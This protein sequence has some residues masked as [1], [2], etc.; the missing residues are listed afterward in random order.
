MA[1]SQA[2]GL[3]R[4]GITL[5]FRCVRSNPP[6]ARDFTSSAARGEEMRP[7][8]TP[9]RVR[10]WEGL[11]MF[12]ERASAERVARLSQPPYRYIA[13]LQITESA[14]IVIEKTFRDPTHFRLWAIRGGSWVVYCR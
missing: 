8:H 10:L 13:R 3:S 2:T 11:S 12:T 6:T 5:F 9:E 14:Q 4:Q 1:A 7:P